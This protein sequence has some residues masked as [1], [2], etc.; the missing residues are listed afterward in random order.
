MLSNVATLLLSG[1]SISTSRKTG[2][3]AHERKRFATDLIVMRGRVLDE[4]IAL[5]LMKL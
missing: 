5:A 2:D 1:K 3:W 4:A